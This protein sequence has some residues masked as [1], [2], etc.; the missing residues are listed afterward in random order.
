MPRIAL[1]ARQ[2][3]FSVAFAK[4]RSIS[5]AYREAYEVDPTW[6]A[7]KIDKNARAVIN[8]PAVRDRIEELI[9]EAGKAAVFTVTEA[10]SRFLAIASADP[11]ELVSLRVGACRYCHGQAH[12]YQW[13]EREYLEALDRSERD[14]ANI[15]DIGGG[16][17]YDATATPHPECPECH[18]EG[19]PREVVKD[20]TDL[21]AEGRLLFGGIKHTNSGPQIIIA[22][23]MK[24]LEAACRLAGFFKD[25]VNVTGE[26]KRMDAVVTM[27]ARDPQH[28]AKLYMEMVNG[29]KAD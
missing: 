9:N 3:A 10:I 7:R 15:P 19:V 5:K 22:D 20:T 13:R 23:R 26:L 28:A 27:E 6:D 21:S 29:I 12:G 11:N 18:G 24:A 25:N 14:G 17:D 16:F 2:E 1:T 4:S 8:T